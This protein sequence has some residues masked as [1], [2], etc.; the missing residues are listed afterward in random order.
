MPAKSELLRDVYL[1]MMRHPDGP[2]LWRDLCASLDD[3]TRE[4]A[5]RLMAD[6]SWMKG[7][8]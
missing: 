2:D 7:F 4:E 3:T 5:I 1:T 8:Y 6:P